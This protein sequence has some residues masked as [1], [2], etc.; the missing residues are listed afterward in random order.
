[1]SKEKWLAQG[2]EQFAIGGPASLKVEPLAARTGISKSSFYHHFADLEV[3]EEQLCQL[4]LRRAAGLAERERAA[5]SIDPDLIDIL[6]THKTD[7]LFSRQ[8]RMNRQRQLFENA[9][10]L[11]NNIVGTDFIA[12]WARELRLNLNQA[13]LQVIFGLALENFYLQ[14]QPEQLGADWLR[15]HFKQLRQQLQLLN[16]A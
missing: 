6:V 10:Q 1:M 2:Y 7:L 12:L 15:A 4:H 8:L 16:K 11:S 14:M 5:A 9:L 13:Q 3:F